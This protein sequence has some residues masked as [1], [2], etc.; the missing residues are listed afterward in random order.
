[1]TSTIIKENLN[2]NGI[3]YSSSESNLSLIC[4]KNKDVF[5]FLSPSFKEPVTFD[6]S[7][8][9]KTDITFDNIFRMLKIFSFEKTIEFMTSSIM[10]QGE[11]TIKLN[12]KQRQVAL[13][14]RDSLRIQG[15]ETKE[16]YLYTGWKSV[17]KMISEHS[18]Y[19]NIQKS[20]IEQIKYFFSYTYL[21][22]SYSDEINKL[23]DVFWDQINKDFF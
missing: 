1:M 15:H 11:D 14:V 10:G 6:I 19:L 17:N 8:Y 20:Q 22:L 3:K 5:T 21:V 16:S 2:K 7:N 18:K 13:L 4:K 9:K 12:D 23:N